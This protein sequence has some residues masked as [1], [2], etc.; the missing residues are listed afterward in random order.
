MEKSIAELNREYF[1]GQ[2]SPTVLKLLTMLPSQTLEGQQFLERI[3]RLMRMSNFQANDFSHQLAWILGAI[4][5]KILPGAWGGIV[6]PITSADRHQ[7]IDEY[8]QLKLSDM[9]T[10]E[11]RLIDLGCGF[12]PVTT[13]AT[14]KRF[15]N[16]Q[17]IGLDPSF[18]EYIVYDANGDYAS[19]NQDGEIQYFQSGVLEIDRWDKMFQNPEETRLRFSRLFEQLIGD[20]PVSDPLKA[21]A[22]EKNA[23][24]LIKN[25]VKNYETKQLSFLRG[26]IGQFDIQGADIIRCFNVLFY[27][28]RAFRHQTLKWVVD[29]LKPNGT[30]ICGSNDPLG[31]LCKYTMYLKE[32]EDLVE[33]EFAFSIDNLRPLGIVT[34][35]TLHED[36]YE[37]CRVVDAIGTIRADSEFCR[38]FDIALDAILTEL[39][40]CPRGEDGYLGGI[41]PSIPPMQ[42]GERFLEI[43]N[44]LAQSGY[45][46]RAISVLQKTG[47]NASRNSIGHI[48]I[49]PRNPETIRSSNQ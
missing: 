33:K 9:A 34:W 25:P 4:V 24:K 36:D 44:R 17:I 29:N 5:P 7:K 18:P 37:T 43:E 32:G 6:P 22:I 42:I 11:A 39:G 31:T 46:D 14:T 40:L 15:E 2:L 20:L 48:A 23:I 21:T 1:D 12:P 27:F 49:T 28:D 26:G 10:A 30:F 38:D 19:F 3:F 13:I 47:Y 45:V 41:D 16:W 35:F 8:I